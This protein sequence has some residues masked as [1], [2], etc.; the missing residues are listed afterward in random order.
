MCIIEI[1]ITKPL[2]AIEIRNARKY[3]DL[4]HASHRID[5]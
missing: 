3:R 4:E 1:L 2:M 5:I